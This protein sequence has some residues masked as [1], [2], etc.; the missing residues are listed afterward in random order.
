MASRPASMPLEPEFAPTFPDSSFETRAFERTLGTPLEPARW[1]GTRLR[2]L[3]VV[4]LIGCLSLFL[5]I[6]T[7]AQ[8][9]HVNATWTSNGQ[10]ELVL[11]S[12]TD[13]RLRGFEG[14]ALRGVELDGQ[15]QP[16]DAL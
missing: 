7:L 12:S 8:A 16:L 2:L 15:L 11:S 5:W 3:V 9:P 10:G 1:M 13:P 14:K 4:A 6:R